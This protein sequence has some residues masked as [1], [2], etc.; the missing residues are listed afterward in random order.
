MGHAKGLGFVLRVGA[1][2][3]GFFRKCKPDA[4]SRVFYRILWYLRAN[5]LL[6]RMKYKYKSP[7]HA[8]ALKHRARSF[9][10]IL[11]QHLLLQDLAFKLAE[12]T[13]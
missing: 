5:A 10:A 6:E 11:S 12:E 8:R 3:P 4:D 7:E 9:M 13:I 1:F 2:S